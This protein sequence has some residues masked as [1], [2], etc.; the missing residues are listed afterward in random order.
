MKKTNKFNYTD[1]CRE[2]SGFGG[3]YESACRDMVI[4]GMNWLDKNK[5]A[6]INFKQYKNIYGI[7]FDESKDCKKM[8]KVML[9]VNDGCS[10]AQMQACTNHIMFAHTN[11]W[12]KYIKEMEG[13]LTPKTP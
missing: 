1:G 7:T 13:I 10:G 9:A 2:I 4:V 8:Q 12:D 3:G 5:K 11:G 6:K